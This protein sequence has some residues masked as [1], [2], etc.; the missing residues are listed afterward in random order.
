MGATDEGEGWDLQGQNPRSLQYQPLQLNQRAQDG[1]NQNKC[2]IQAEKAPAQP[3]QSTGL[4][5]C[6]PSLG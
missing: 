2:M 5:E 4:G 1:K 6:R 3:A